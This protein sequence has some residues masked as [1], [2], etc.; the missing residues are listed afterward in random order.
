MLNVISIVLL[1]NTTERIFALLSLP[2]YDSSSLLPPLKN[3]KLCKPL[4]YY[5]QKKKYLYQA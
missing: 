5:E 1:I 2:Y 4:L 3:T